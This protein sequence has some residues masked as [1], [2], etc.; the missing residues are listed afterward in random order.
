MTRNV[1][2][3]IAAMV[4]NVQALNDVTVPKTWAARDTLTRGNLNANNDTI[5]TRINQLND[6][7]DLR[8]VRFSDVKDSTFQ[9]VKCDSIRSNP[10]IDSISGNPRI[11]TL[12]VTTSMT[13]RG[14][15][16]DTLT[17]TKNVTADSGYSSKAWSAPRLRGDSATIPILTGNVITRGNATVDSGYATKSFTTARTRTDSLK[18]GSGSFLSSY[19]QSAAVACTLWSNAN[20]SIIAIGTARYTR[21]G[22]LMFLHLPA[23]SGEVRG[24]NGAYIDIN[25][26]AWPIN[27]SVLIYIPIQIYENTGWKLGIIEPT[28]G[29]AWAVYKEDN[30]ALA[31]GTCSIP[32]TMIV[33]PTDYGISQ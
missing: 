18:I 23:L 28:R 14:A 11:D 32:E 17:V 31:N 8:F 24:S 25:S 6:S 13:S 15:N 22:N 16:I 3:V 1:A 30:S 20:D 27:D 12:T 29:G 9:K 21:I 7:L 10:D 33:Y 4:L 26:A 2:M 19:T 5:Y